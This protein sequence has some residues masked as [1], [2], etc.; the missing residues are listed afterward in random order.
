MAFSGAIDDKGEE[1]TESKLNVRKDGSHISENQTK[2]EFHDNFNVLIVAEKYQPG[3]DEPLLHTMIVDKKLKNV[4]AVQMLSRLNR[5]CEG[6]TDTFVLD[7]VNKAEDIKDAFQPFYQETCL[8]EEVNADL[9]YQTQRELR[10]YGIYSDED[11][12]DEQGHTR[13]GQNKFCV[14]HRYHHFVDVR[15]LRITKKMLKLSR[16]EACVPLF[17]EGIKAFTDKYYKKGRQDDRAMG[18]MSSIL[19]PVSN[20]Y[21]K[22]TQNERYQFRNL[23]KW[24]SYIS[25]ILRMFDKELQKEYVFCSYLIGLLPKD[26]VELIDLDG[27][28]KLE[29][30]KLQKTFQ[31]EIAL[32]EAKTAYVPAKHR[33]VKGMDEKTP[34]D[35]VI[36]KINEKF[37]GNF[38]EGDK[39]ILSTLRDKLLSDK[40]LKAFGT[41]AQDGYMEAQ[42]SY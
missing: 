31:G 11:T 9:L 4:K 42:E 12:F 21:N 1:Y 2:A 19:L 13:S 34:L 24:Y 22:K 39:V 18:R 17:I 6:K 23:I 26:P 20:R 25:Q 36:A 5:T 15:R 3:V 33:G 16:F 29:Y 14:L 28:L 41:A 7:F 10:A 40:K 8:Q 38:T 37:K 32:D 27:K 35:E 30:Y